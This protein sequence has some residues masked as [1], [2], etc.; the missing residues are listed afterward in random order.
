[1]N[2]PFVER[3][4]KKVWDSNTN[5]NINEYLL[6]RA[7]LISSVENVHELFLTKTWSERL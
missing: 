6:D 5:I 1:M 3:F 7:A 2:I 4:N